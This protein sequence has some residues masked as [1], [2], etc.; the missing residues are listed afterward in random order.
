MGL[1]VQDEKKFNNGLMLA[2]FVISLKGS[3]NNIIKTSIFNDN[4]LTWSIVYRVNYSVY[5]FANQ[6]AYNEKCN[7]LDCVSSSIDLTPEEINLD[8]F[9]SIYSHISAQYQ[10]T[11]NLI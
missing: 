9:G 4:S 5:Y 3:I 2:N 1:L 11:I 7:W 10:Q 6:Q 8:I